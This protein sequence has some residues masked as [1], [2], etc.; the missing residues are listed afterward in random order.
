[1]SLEHFTVA[2]FTLIAT[3]NAYG[4]YAQASKQ[5]STAKQLTHIRSLCFIT[6]KSRKTQGNS[7]LK[8][9][10]VVYFSVH[11]VVIKVSLR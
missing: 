6:S 7:N 5:G 10:H 11:F 3:Q 1:M 9:K 4:S 2:K 8:I